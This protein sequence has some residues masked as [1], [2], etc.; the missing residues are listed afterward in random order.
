M[1]V[2]MTFSI[3]YYR[4][5]RLHL[6]KVNMPL[7][8]HIIVNEVF[9]HDK[10]SLLALILLLYRLKLDR[11]EEL[12]LRKISLSFLV[13]TLSRCCPTSVWP[14]DRGLRAFLLDNS[15][16]S[17]LVELDREEFLVVLKIRANKVERAHCSA[18]L[19]MEYDLTTVVQFHV[20]KVFI[21]E[22]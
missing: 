6:H 18:T 7:S 8:L 19:Y 16:L 4:A 17:L 22:Y 1:V 11:I 5:K 14:G 3:A 12:L 15:A 9:E 21:Y 10:W 20:D 13:F 2:F